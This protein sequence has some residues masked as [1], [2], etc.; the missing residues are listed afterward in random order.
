VNPLQID[1]DGP[2][3]T[4]AQRREQARAA[5]LALEQA[6]VE[7][8][9]RRRRVRWLAGV[10]VVVVSAVLAILI[11]TGQSAGQRKVAPESAQ[12]RAVAGRVTALLAGIP[13]RG[14]VLGRPSA[15]VTLQYFGDLQCPVCRSFTAQALP[16][17]I[18]RWVR[19]G[20]LKVEYR[21]LETATREPEVFAEQQIA[22]LAAGQQNR[23]WNFLE[24][25]YAEQGEEGSGYVTEG[26]IR[27]IARQIP[28]LDL[29]RWGAARA[30]ATL[31]QPVASDAQAAANDG[32]NGT[33]AFLIG[34][35]GR[36][37]R[38]FEPTSFTD[39]QSFDHAIEAS[40]A[41]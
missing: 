14:D 29:A 24:T 1:H 33:P 8:D 2:V 32:L 23:M 31:A 11:A 30:D 40:L 37:A 4:R 36:V 20:D 19:A 10:L 41:G 18:H 9:L 34:R 12:A 16:P 15:P 3:L 35:S 22:A 25:F 28:G 21:S 7:R 39:P 5:R 17:L 38:T 6:R 27:G 26:F 13:Q